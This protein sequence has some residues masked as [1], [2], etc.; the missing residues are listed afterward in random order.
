MTY[1][2][3]TGQRFGRL[4]AQ[5]VEYTTRKNARSIIV[6]KCQCDCGNT[7]YADGNNLRRGNTLSCGCLRSEKSKQNIAHCNA[8]RK[9][10]TP[11]PKSDTSI[12]AY[13]VLIKATGEEYYFSSVT[14]IFGTLKP[15]QLGCKLRTLWN[16]NMKKRGAFINEECEIKPITILRKKHFSETY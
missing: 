6:W 9:A 4:V 10:R 16:Y 7:Y 15:E 5:S 14:A 3:I 2:D 13:R 1:K 11:K 12:S 8:T